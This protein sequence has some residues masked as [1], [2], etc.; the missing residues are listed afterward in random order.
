MKKTCFLIALAITS[1]S[2]GQISPIP[3]D[4]DWTKEPPLRNVTN[5]GK[6]LSDIESHMPAGH[7]Y[8]DSDK[9]T[10]GHETTHGINSRL[11]QKYSRRGYTVIENG[12]KPTFKSLDSINC[13]YVLENRAA[14]IKEPN[15][16]IAS[17]ADKVPQSLRGDVF[18]LYMIQSRRWWNNTP[19]YVFDEWVAYG[20]GAA[21]RYDL[22]IQ[23]RSET[24]LY[25][26]EFIVYS[27]AVLQAA[28]SDDQ[29]LKDFFMWNAERT[30]NLYKKNRPTAKQQ[31]YLQ[32]LRTSRDGE[33]LRNY[34]RG[35]CGSYWCQRILGF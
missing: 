28:K 29:Q 7:I 18:N 20:N 6:V 34:I 12:R 8:R 13:F 30:M 27:M 24:V 22:N 33:S 5:L 11:R 1:I 9:I 26:L 32:K 23:Q 16:T 15:T 19:L 17:A 21:V 10:W 2:Y 25:S 31:E 4:P 14:I 3:Q 35:Y